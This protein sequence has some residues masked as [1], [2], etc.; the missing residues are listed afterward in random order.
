M[1][2]CSWCCHATIDVAIHRLIVGKVTFLGATIQVGWNGYFAHRLEQRGKSDVVAIPGESYLERVS[3][4]FAACCCDSNVVATDTDLLHQVAT[5]PAL[6]VAHKTQPCAL[7]CGLENEL[8]VVW[9]N[10][11]EAEDFNVATGCFLETESSID[12]SGV[13]VNEDGIVGEQR[14]HLVKDVLWDVVVLV[15]KHFALLTLSQRVLCNSLIGERVV[16]VGDAQVAHI[17]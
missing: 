13:V 1:E 16:I 9:H 6:A 11:L 15:H 7:C 17:V 3:T 4:A 12:Y 5:L 10:W 2:A 8:V 14:W